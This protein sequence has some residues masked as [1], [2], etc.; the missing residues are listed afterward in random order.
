MKKRTAGQLNVLDMTELVLPER[1]N[2]IA[3]LGY[4]RSVSSV[5]AHRLPVV[6]NISAL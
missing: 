2:F 3:K 5:I 6:C 1:C 4:C